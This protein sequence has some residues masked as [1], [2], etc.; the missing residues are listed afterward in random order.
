MGSVGGLG[1]EFSIADNL[2]HIAAPC[3]G[4]TKGDRRRI[5]LVEALPE[6]TA[7][8]AQNRAG[9]LLLTR[10][11]ESD[12]GLFHPQR[13]IFKDRE[14]AHGGSGDGRPPG[15]P[16]NLRGLEVLHVDGLLDR[17]MVDRVLVEEV[18]HLIAD[19]SEAFGHRDF[20][21]YFQGGGFEQDGIAPG[22]V[23][24]DG[25][26]TATQAGVDTEHATGEGLSQDDIRLRT[27][28]TS[29]LLGEVFR[30]EFA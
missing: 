3:K 25:K 7:G 15:G 5:G 26:T 4:V 2:Y 27:R 1:S 16:Q 23:F 19:R 22:A 12:H 13:G 8:Q 28:R 29:T 6:V 11:A 17:H 24:D 18:V 20:R 10:A 21:A 9:D 14:P 30:P